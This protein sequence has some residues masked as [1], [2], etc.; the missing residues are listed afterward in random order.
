MPLRLCQPGMRLGRSIFSDEGL[1]LLG[2]HM[3]LT[4]AFLRRLDKFGI[5]FLYIEDPRTDDIRVKDRVSQETRARAV[6]EVRTQFRR[7]M[8]DAMKRR[9]VNGLHLGRA[10]RSI[11]ESILDDI[12]SSRD[13]MLMLVNIHASDHYLFQHSVNVCIYTA[14][15]GQAYGY[16]RDELYTL[17]LGALLHDIGKTQLPA[18]VLLKPSSLT[19]EEFELMKTHA[20]LGFRK[21]KDEPNVPLLSAHIALQHH[22]RIN[23]SGYPR[24]IAGDEIHEYARW[25]G[26]ADSYDAMTTHRVYRNAMLP[27]EAMERLYAGAGTLYDQDKIELFRDKVAIYPLGMLVT[28]DNGATGVIVDVN[29]LSPQRPVVRVLYDDEGQ[30]VEPYE[31]DLSKTLTAT[32]KEANVTA[33]S[34]GM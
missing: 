23:G 5:Q 32:I 33:A 26:I 2:E 3:E 1:V 22:E 25:V 4:D 20:A 11:V 31:V 34:M 21:L 19:H 6:A 9:S 8:D 28:L 29:A 16:S 18:E 17:S 12:T 30:A 27:H 15:L 10:F 13:S 7:M 24:G 14:I